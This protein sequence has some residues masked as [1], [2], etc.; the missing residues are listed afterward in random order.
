M[1]NWTGLLGSLLAVVPLVNALPAGQSSVT[2]TIPRPETRVIGS[3]KGSVETFNGIPYARQPVGPLRLR[4]PQRQ[5]ESLGTIDAT[6][7][8][9]SCPQF[10]LPTDESEFPISLLGQLLNHPF[11]QHVTNTGEDCLNLNVQRPRGT[12]PDAKLPVLFWIFGGGFELG[13]TAMYDASSLVEE[14]VRQGK[15]IM[16]VAV[17]YRL[18]G[19]GFMPGKEI[20]ADG[21]A[22]LGLLDQRLGLEWVA[23]NI[24]AFG[25]DPSRVT[26]WGQSAGSI[27]VLDQMLL[28]GGDN[29]YN[30]NPLF[31]GAIMNSGTVAPADPVDCPKGQVVY[32][33]V[34]ENAGCESAADTL[35]CLRDLDYSTFLDAANSVPGI[36]GYHSIALSYVPRP[37]GTALPESPNILVDEGRYARVPFIAGD[38]EDEG[39]FFALFQPNLTTT[40]DIVDYLDTLPFHNAG[41]TVLQEYVAT[42]QRIGEDGS[43]FRTSFLNNWYPQFKRLA[44][45][46]G[47]VTFTLARR[48]FLETTSQVSPEVPSWSYLA[49][50]YY[51]TPFLGTFHASDVLQ[52]FYGLPHP[53]AARTIRGYYFSFVYNQDPN[54]PKSG[55]PIWPRWSERRQMMNF[56][57]NRAYMM[58]DDF[59][60]DSADVLRRNV[61]AFYI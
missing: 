14:S 49:T 29:T 7:I 15:P 46:L 5:N 22:N 13:S 43:P 59:R 25:G 26:I 16:F 23:D 52:V 48:L 44:A 19:F 2:V 12:A 57:A 21:A 33:T 55:R 50:Y 8:P 35:E 17:K 54:D 10:L 32:D 42:Y 58:A 41:R 28:Y 9:R 47:D 45:I 24:A 18:G 1:K 61:Q 37:D 20:L 31:H 4:P 27:S 51:G 3:R 34:V 40:N 53:Y 38:Q 36:V 30:G 39:S 60:A 6:G 11:V 56:E